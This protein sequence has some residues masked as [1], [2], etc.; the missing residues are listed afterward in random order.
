MSGA[1]T[2]DA[3]KGD[4]A[5]RFFFLEDRFDSYRN[6]EGSGNADEV[7]FWPIS[8]FGDFIDNILNESVSEFR[9]EFRGDDRDSNF[10]G[11]DGTG[12]G[13]NDGRHESG[14]MRKGPDFVNECQSLCPILT[15][16]V[17]RYFSL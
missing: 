1:S 3:A 6:L 5:I 15:R 9:V 12:S 17:S 8:E 16:L 7:D 2:D 4:D 10:S 11:A 13:R 14:D